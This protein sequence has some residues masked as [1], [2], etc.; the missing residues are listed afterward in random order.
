M[1]SHIMILKLYSVMNLLY[2]L[3]L[4]NDRQV[5]TGDACVLNYCVCLF[6]VAAV[7]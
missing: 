2:N 4:E 1:L 3:H 6:D 5:R 7:N